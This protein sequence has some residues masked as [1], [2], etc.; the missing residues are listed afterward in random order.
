MTNS[1]KI[2]SDGLRALFPEGSQARVELTKAVFNN[3]MS[4]E[5]RVR[6][7]PETSA[8]IN[9]VK[10]VIRNEYEQQVR[11]Q[12]LRE[13]TCSTLNDSVKNNISN[14][15][16]LCINRVI[17]DKLLDLQREIKRKVENIAC[18][19]EQLYKEQVIAEVRNVLTKDIQATIQA[20]Q[21]R[22]LDD[23]NNRNSSN[24]SN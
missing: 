6:L 18:N 11:T 15:V 1:V 8:E 23:L 14:H 4:N 22:I 7:T 12:V 21:Q 13:G 2:D 5:L 16:A 3:F 24:P 9:K 19:L 17:Q 10:A 20:T